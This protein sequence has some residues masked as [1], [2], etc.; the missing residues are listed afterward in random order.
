MSDS[1]ET[2][3][4]PG[5]PV[6]LVPTPV[7]FWRLVLG[8]CITTFAP[9]FG[10]LYGTMMGAPD[11]NAALSPMYLGLF[12][13]FVLGGLGLGM[14]IMGAWRMWSAS[15]RGRNLEEAIS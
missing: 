15:R 12:I 2:P 8:L 1:T 11:P 14:A 4:Q 5:R 10:F 9:L 3:I 6:R 7:G 13:G